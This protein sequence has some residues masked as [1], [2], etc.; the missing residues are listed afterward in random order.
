MED[1]P[2]ELRIDDTDPNDPKLI[3]MQLGKQIMLRRTDEGEIAYLI[4]Q[5][6]L[7]IFKQRQIEEE[8]R[9]GI[10]L[11]INDQYYKK[12]ENNRKVIQ[13]Y[14]NLRNL[15]LDVEPDGTLKYKSLSR[16]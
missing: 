1:F 3:D 15:S 14:I 6:N 11:T 16:F 2:V 5:W 12:F 10:K 7:N 4:N 8:R 9:Q 13:K